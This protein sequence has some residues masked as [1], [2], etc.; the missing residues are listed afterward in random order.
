[1]F[2]RIIIMYYDVIILCIAL[3]YHMYDLIL[4]SVYTLIRK[5]ISF[6]SFLIIMLRYLKSY[7]LKLEN[8][9]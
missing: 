1:M 9:D 3:T 4:S 7:Y 6:L 8:F 2:R 5:D